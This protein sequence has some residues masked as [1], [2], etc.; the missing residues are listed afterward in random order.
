M[1]TTVDKATPVFAIHTLNA[2]LIGILMVGVPAITGVEFGGLRI[3][4]TQWIQRLLVGGLGLGLAANFLMGWGCRPRPQRAAY[5]GWMLLHAGFLVVAMLTF[6]G[7]IH[8][9]WLRVFLQELGR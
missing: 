7:L 2:V 9:K 4:S 6:S 1:K 3:S 8:F 5:R